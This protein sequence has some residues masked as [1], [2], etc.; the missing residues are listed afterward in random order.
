MT[1]RRSIPALICAIAALSVANAQTTFTNAA[2][3]SVT[4]NGGSSEVKASGGYPST[5]TIPNTVTGTITN[6]AVVLNQFNANGSSATGTQGLGILLVH[7]DSGHNLEIMGA[8]SD[9]NESFTNV[10]FYISDTAVVTPANAFGYMP[11]SGFPCGTSGGAPWSPTSGTMDYRPSSYFLGASAGPTY[12]T[13]APGTI[14]RSGPCSPNSGTLMGTFGS[15]TPSGTWQLYVDDGESDIV[16]ISGGWS[17]ILTVSTSSSPTTTTLTSNLNPSFASSPSNS[18]TLTATVSSSGGTVA[19]T[20]AFTD[21]GVGIA[22]CGGVAISGGMAQCTTTF[23]PEGFHGLTATTSPTGSFIGSSGTLTQFVE[24]HA[25]TGTTNQYCNTG[26]ITVGSGN[27]SGTDTQPYPSVINV[28]SLS[29]TTV[30]TVSLVLKGLSMTTTSNM[31]M[32]LVSPDGTH[33]LDFFD[34]VG[35]AVQSPTSGT[36]TDVTFS[37]SGVEA[38]T[39]EQGGGLAGPTADYLPTAFRSSSSFAQTPSPAPQVPATFGL[40]RP[41]R[42]HPEYFP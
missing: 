15:D 23:S 28:P 8:P 24:N 12:P 31:S 33:A 18:V 37:D 1:I 6:I 4:G 19:G 17:L 11:S 22:G 32:L 2:A 20:V 21:G 38:P 36:T 3:I 41:G 5:I 29:A 7:S 13:P 16:A 9:G 40:P 39:P 35:A 34:N 27:V 10:P 26:G 14:N 42:K 30:S 25:S